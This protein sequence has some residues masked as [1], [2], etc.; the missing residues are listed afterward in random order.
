MKHKVFPEM[1][2][3]VKIPFLLVKAYH[4]DT[5]A[6]VIHARVWLLFFCTTKFYTA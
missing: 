3:R 4:W 5:A 6:A 1:F 2:Y